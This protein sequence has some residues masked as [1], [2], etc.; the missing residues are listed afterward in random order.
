M[1]DA[2]LQRRSAHF[3]CRL[4][5]S[6]QALRLVDMPGFQAGAGMWEVSTMRLPLRR[7]RPRRIVYGAW[8]FFWRLMRARWAECEVGP[9]ARQ[10]VELT[11]PLRG[12]WLGNHKLPMP[13]AKRL[14]ACLDH[15]LL[16]P[17]A[18]RRPGKVVQIGAI[19]PRHPPR[20]QVLA[21]SPEAIALEQARGRCPRGRCI[22]SLITSVD[23]L[24]SN[25]SELYDGITAS[26]G[27]VEHV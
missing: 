18:Q 25:A 11:H 5:I 20:R 21:P 3:T 6:R 15:P 9:T 22:T 23:L 17:S 4:C 13:S 8:Q 14:R 16:A 24:L 26:V 2:S 1:H 12:H 10:R 7:W 19:R 27:S